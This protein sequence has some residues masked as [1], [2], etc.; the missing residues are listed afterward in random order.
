[1]RLGPVEFECTASEEFLKD[2]LP[3]LIA[4]MA[5]LYKEHFAD[6]HTQVAESDPGGANGSGTTVTT[7]NQIELT[8]S[9]IAAKLKVKTGP[10]L[11][12]AA[13]L[14]LSRMGKATFTRTELTDRMREAA[15]YFKQT[16]LSN[17]TQN[18]NSL[19]TTGKLLENA[20]D[21]YALG[22]SARNELEARLAR[23]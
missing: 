10:E 17:L 22:E 13:A 1:M 8:T 4:G 15:A 21:T 2:E 19:L 23:P 12:L 7:P 14:R 11:I 20:K 5:Q 3:A 6:T 16:Y 18:L 9:S